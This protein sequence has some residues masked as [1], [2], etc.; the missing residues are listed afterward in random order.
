MGYLV[1]VHYSFS[2]VMSSQAAGDTVVAKTSS[3]K[4]VKSVKKPA[5]EH[6]TYKEMVSAALAALRDR[7]GTSRQ[8]VLKHIKANYKVKEGCETHVKGAL[9]RGVTS[10]TFVQLTGKGSSGSFKLAKV[11]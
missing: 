1:K 6:P 4:S 9:V 11:A 5:P 8:A 10:G 2:K 7:K 3:K